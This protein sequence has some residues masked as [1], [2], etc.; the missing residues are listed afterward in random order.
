VFGK[1]E[2]ASEPS[3]SWIKRLSQMLDH[4]PAVGNLKRRWGS[5]SSSFGK[6]AGPIKTD[7]FDPWML[8]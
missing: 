4:M 2:I 8:P 3:Q 6:I 1:S 5:Q 7:D